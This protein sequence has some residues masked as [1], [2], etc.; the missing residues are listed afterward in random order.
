MR[1]ANRSSPLCNATQARRAG[2]RTSSTIGTPAGLETDSSTPAHPVHI[3]GHQIA[4]PSLDRQE[5]EQRMGDSPRPVR[6]GGQLVVGQG[7]LV[8]TSGQVVLGPGAM[9]ER[10]SGR[11]RD[12]GGPLRPGRAIPPPRACRV[13]RA[14]HQLHQ[15][16]GVLVGR[17]RDRTRAARPEPPGSTPDCPTGRA[18]T[19]MVAVTTLAARRVSPLAMASR[20]AASRS[21]RSSR[22]SMARCCASRSWSCAERRQPGPQERPEEVVKTVT[23]PRRRRR[24]PR[25]V[26][27]TPAPPTAGRRR[28]PRSPPGTTTRRTPRARRW[29]S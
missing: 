12:P 14:Q 19:E 1:R 11:G 22:A 2:R 23:L 16:F 17:R 21:P 18:T 20:R 3:S 29:W 4:A 24:P 26:R 25:T 13:G 15:L 9:Q 27:P 6:L 28:A 10:G 5:R 8:V 7:L